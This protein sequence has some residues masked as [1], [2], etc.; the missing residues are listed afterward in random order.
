MFQWLHLYFSTLTLQWNTWNLNF[1]SF[2][3]PELAYVYMSCSFLSMLTKALR[4]VC[5]VCSPSFEFREVARR[6]ARPAVSTTEGLA[7]NLW[8]LRPLFRHFV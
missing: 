2:E 8:V 3:M 4:C 1:M 7:S 6:C 5:F